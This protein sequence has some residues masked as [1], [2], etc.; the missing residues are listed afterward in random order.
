MKDNK[1]N[2]N[3]SD[4]ITHS[5]SSSSNKIISENFTY[6]NAEEYTDMDT[7]SSKSLTDSNMSNRKNSSL[8]DDSSFS[9]IGS[10]KNELNIVFKNLKCV[11]SSFIKFFGSILMFI[12][13]ILYSIVSYIFNIFNNNSSKY[14]KSSKSSSKSSSNSCNKSSN[15]SSSKS[16][17]YKKSYNNKFSKN[18]NNSLISEINKIDTDLSKIKNNFDSNKKKKN[19]IKKSSSS[20]LSSSSSSSSSSTSYSSSSPSILQNNKYCRKNDIQPNN[21]T[22]TFSHINGNLKKTHQKNNKKNIS[23]HLNKNKKIFKKINEIKNDKCEKKNKFEKNNLIK[24]NSDSICE[25]N[26]EMMNEIYKILNN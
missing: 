1:K 26:T 2:L 17:K 24:T 21:N 13:K 16:C 14:S 4:F 6:S 25:G 18:N 8:F 19:I 20:S 5:K 11:S 7:D 10:S 15:K 22:Y 12:Y 3:I 9:N 23:K